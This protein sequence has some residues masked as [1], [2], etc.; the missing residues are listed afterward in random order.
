KSNLTLSNALTTSSTTPTFAFFGPLTFTGTVLGNGQASDTI[1]LTSQD[2][3]NTLFKLCPLQNIEVTGEGIDPAKT[4]TSKQLTKD[5]AGHFTV[6]FSSALDRSLVAQPGG[7]YAYTFG[8]PLVPLI[9][10][11]GF[12]WANVEPLVGK[13]NHGAQLTQNTKDWTFTDSPTQ[14]KMW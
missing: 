13:F 8:S 9:R 3:Y 12:E 11:P 5:N 7:Y 1:F 2:A 4:S 10:D 6:Q 14:P